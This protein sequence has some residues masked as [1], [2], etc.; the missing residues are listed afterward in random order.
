MVHAR[1]IEYQFGWWAY[2]HVH[3]EAKNNRD[4]YPDSISLIADLDGG[5]HKSLFVSQIW[6][7]MGPSINFLKLWHDL[8]DNWDKFDSKFTKLFIDRYTS[9]KH[10]IDIK[11]DSILSTTRHEIKKLLSVMEELNAEY[12]H[13]PIQISSPN[14]IISPNNDTNND[15]NNDGIDDDIDDTNDE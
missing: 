1:G 11:G 14:Q 12:L 3:P 8:L 2:C 6:C 15:A 4:S 9:M 10:Y 13:L 5:Y 7:S